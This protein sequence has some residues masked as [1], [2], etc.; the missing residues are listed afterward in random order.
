MQK[1]YDALTAATSLSFGIALF[2]FVDFRGGNVCP[3]NRK[4]C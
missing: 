3:W 2:E 4:S 1:A